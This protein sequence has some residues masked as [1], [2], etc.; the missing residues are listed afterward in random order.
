MLR[1]PTKSES[2]QPLMM[3]TDYPK[4][5]ATFEVLLMYL[6]IFLTI[7]QCFLPRFSM[8]RLIA[9]TAYAMFG[10][11]QIIANIKLPIANVYDI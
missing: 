1:S 5:N 11:A 8:N 9:P 4:H 10:L 6:S 7:F 2:I 3:N